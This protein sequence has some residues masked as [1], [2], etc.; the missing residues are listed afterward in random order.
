[1]IQKKTIVISIF[2]IISTLGY[3]QNEKVFEDYEY[4][5]FDERIDF[6]DS[7]IVNDYPYNYPDVS[8]CLIDLNSISGI[9]IDYKGVVS[10]SGDDS[11][12]FIIDKDKYN[13]YIK[14]LRLF[15]EKIEMMIR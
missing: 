12:M 10:I 9:G 8:Y 1:M 3:S 15:S 6:M 13:E 5:T 11:R 4:K 14:K 7:L 2:L